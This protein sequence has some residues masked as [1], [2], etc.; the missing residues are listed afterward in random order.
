MPYIVV[1]R[2]SSMLSAMIHNRHQ[3]CTF[4]NATRGMSALCCVLCYVITVLLFSVKLLWCKHATVSTVLD[5][6]LLMMTVSAHEWWCFVE[7]VRNKSQQKIRDPAGIWTTH[8]VWLQYRNVFFDVYYIYFYCF[9]VN[10]A[11]SSCYYFWLPYWGPP[12]CRA[13]LYQNIFLCVWFM[14]RNC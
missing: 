12:T 4:Y 14:F 9:L 11:I 13:P 3:L 2:G 6:I 8:V 10:Q 1:L 7:W 5:D